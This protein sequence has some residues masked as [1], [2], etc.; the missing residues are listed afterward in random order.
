[1]AR[2][3][4]LRRSE[5]DREILRLAVPA[6]GA[7]AAEP[8]YVLADTAIVGRLG[9]HPL[10]GLAVASTVLIAAF[11]VF[12][13]LA[14]GTTAAVARRVGA[15]DERGA[16]EHGVA[17][18]WFALGLG[19][20]LTVGGLLLSSTIVDAMGASADIAPYARTYLRISLLGAPFVLLALAGTGYLRGLQDTRT[21]LVIAVGANTLN[22]VLE[23]VLVYG[24]DLGIAGSAWG[25]VIAQ[26]V[27]ATAY[28]AIVARNVRHADASIRPSIP[29]LR[30][31][32]IVGG[33]LTIRTG[34]LLLAFTVA[35]A[36][37]SRLGDV[38]VAAHQVAFQLWYF[39]ALSLD[40]IAIAGQAIVGRYLGASDLGGTRATTRRM[41]EL[42]IMAGVVLG[43]LVFVATPLI[44]R[45]FTGDGD[46]QHELRVLLPL[47]ALMQPLNAAVFV[48]DGILIGA[49]DVR[50]LALAMVGATAVFLPLAVL[51]LVTDAGLVALWG[52]LY[53]FMLARLFGMGVRYRG[54]A[55]AVTGAVHH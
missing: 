20:L 26:I 41:L 19:L 34:S 28:L 42:G 2:T 23:I 54:D 11:G 44:A 43:V 5:H 27:A 50:Y 24:I 35:T 15:G 52:A 1:V 38:E 18:L 3:V 47:V 39:L 32:A 30:A 31:T 21:P 17:G 55:W 25:T 13:F 49:G 10:G 45:L 37:A 51:V 16:A 8:L 14:Y 9:T 4:W 29:R 36:I 46:V 22:L 33:H 12:N 6:F 48:L 53:A 40:A 7:L